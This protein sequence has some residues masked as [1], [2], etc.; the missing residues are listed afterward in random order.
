MT[1]LVPLVRAGLRSN[2]GLSV[3]RHRLFVE[4]RDRWLAAL[5]GAAALGVLPS[6]YGLILLAQNVYLALKPLGQEP[7]LLTLGVLAGQLFILL[8]GLYSVI[9]AFYFSRDLAFL[10]TTRLGDRPGEAELE[11][12]RALAL[13]R[14][15]G[16]ILKPLPVPAPLAAS[17]REALASLF[18]EVGVLPR[19][20]PRAGQSSEFQ[21]MVEGRAGLGY[22][23]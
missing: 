22:E 16:P 2:F 17:A 13:E 1:R 23:F 12:A 18:A 5:I 21:W 6:I 19:S 4:K 15:D 14:A 9:S 10:V 7:A 20:V 8:F 3:L 11:A